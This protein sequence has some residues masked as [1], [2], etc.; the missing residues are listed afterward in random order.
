MLSLVKLYSSVSISGPTTRVK[1]NSR[2]MSQISSTTAVTGCTAPRH[3]G[4]P[5]MVPSIRGPLSAARASWASRSAMACS[6]CCLSWLA[7]APTSR[8]SS[9]EREAS[10]RSTWVNLPALRPRSSVRRSVRVEASAVATRAAARPAPRRTSSGE[11]LV[12]RRRGPSGALS[13]DL[14]ELPERDRVAHGEIGQHLAV[15]LHPRPLETGHE[16]GVR[17]LVQARRR[18]DPGNPQAPELALLLPAVTVRVPPAPLHRLLGGLEEFAPPAA[19]ALGQAHDLLLALEA[20]DVAFHSRHGALLTPAARAES[21]ARPPARPAPR[22]AVA[23][24]AWDASWSG[25]DS[26]W[27]VC[28]ARAPW[29]SA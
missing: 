22:A 7:R 17:Q 28:A 12:I 23:V 3:M 2:K 21:A 5:G 15:D 13:R 18:V 27:P 16:P 24:S 19:R 6:I 10:E 11:R 26:C 29:R 1:P 14:R 9:G 4:R 20:R 25:C 8:R